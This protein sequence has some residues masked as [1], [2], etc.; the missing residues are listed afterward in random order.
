MRLGLIINP[1]S[2]GQKGAQVGAEV[3]SLLAASSHQII[4]LSG[5]NLVEAKQKGENSIS[6][7]QIDALILVGGD[8]MV[9]LGTNLC[10]GR[11]IPMAIVP[12]GTGND[13]AEVFGMPKDDTQKSVELI[14][15]NLEKPIPVDAISVEHDGVTSWS[16]GSVSAGF[17]ALVNARANRMKWPKGPN[18][19]YLAMLLELASFKP[20]KYR[21]V[22]DGT[23]GEFEAMLCVVSNSGV[24]GGGM[25]VVP[26]ASITDGVL[27]L[28]MLN[29]ISRA[30]FVAI[31]PRVYEGTHITDPAVEIISAKSV[32]MEAKGMPIYS[33]GEYVGQAPFEAK[34]VPGA[35][36]VVAPGLLG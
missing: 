29:K 11:G 19:Y 18:R 30:H 28:M 7:G 20:I 8:G 1:S 12:A 36:L 14:L 2:G 35:L 24:F 21:S 3:K 31:F 9:Y 32:R 27:N 16:F 10:A 23:E 5:T 15:N 25:K 4:D 34:V 17:D 6:E 22:I 13:A 26:S 33:D